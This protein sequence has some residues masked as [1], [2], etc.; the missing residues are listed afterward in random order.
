[1]RDFQEV[2]DQASKDIEAYRARN[3][4][5]DAMDAMANCIWNLPTEAKKEFFRKTVSAAPAN[6]LTTGIK[7]LSAENPKIK[8]TP[9]G[10]DPDDR[11]TASAIERG[12]LWE[13]KSSAR[14]SQTKFVPDLNKS[15]LTYAECAVFV[16][17][18][19]DRI[20]AFSA[21]RQKF[22][23]RNGQFA[24]INFHPNSVYPRYSQLG[25]EGV[26][27]ARQMKASQVVK[28]WGDK[29]SKVSAYIQDKGEDP[30]VFLF[31]DMDYEQRTVWVSFENDINN[32]GDDQFKI[33]DE[34]RQ[35]GF[36]PWAIRMH[37]TS[38]SNDP[39]VQRVPFL[40]TVHKARLWETM[41]L[42]GTIINSEALGYAAAPRIKVSDPNGEIIKVDY[43]DINKKIIEYPG[44]KV[45]PFPPVPLDTALLEIHDRTKAELDDA[46]SVQILQN[47]NFPAGTAY[48]SINAVLQTATASLQP[49]KVLSEMTL[50]DVCTIMLLW[51]DARDGQITA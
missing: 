44:H 10:P 47:L 12:L 27:S 48:A 51:I 32:V 42:S 29:A 33:M 25:L 19:P 2:L 20:S 23:L 18:L 38:L 30:D 41:N 22:I 26:L 35:L 24:L 34:E 37:G 7:V 40:D 28:Y 46:T 31:D 36:I 13:I 6:A 50:A 15:S 11:A 43:G 8:F 16:D 21:A 45:E 17:Y 3:A 9:I 39:A 14:R 5:N 1:M 4:K 49:Y